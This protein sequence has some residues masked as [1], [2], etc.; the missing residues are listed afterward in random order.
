D[1]FSAILGDSLL[2]VSSEEEVEQLAFDLSY[3]VL[4]DLPP[5]KDLLVKLLS[6]KNP[7]R[8]YVHFYKENSEFF[9]T[10]PTREHFKWFYAFL[11]KKSP[12]DL[13]RYGGELA[14]HRGWTKET[15]EFMSQV[16]F[17]LDFVKINNGFISLEKDVPKRDLTESKTYQHK[18]QAFTLENELLY[19]S[20]EQLKDWFD[21]FIQE[22]VK[23]EEAIIQWI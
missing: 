15:I 1:K 7:G 12:F 9:T 3:V 17:E 19:S 2:L 13:K 18:V 16:F 20:Y 8:I 11:S 21:Q 23:N 4:L 10:M 5:S 14:K 6:G 22:S